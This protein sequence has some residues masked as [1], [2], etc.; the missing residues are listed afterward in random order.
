M[1]TVKIQTQALLKKVRENRVKH[2][3]E[4]EEAMAGYREEV[5]RELNENLSKATTGEDVPH[6][7]SLTQPTSYCHDYDRVIAMLEMS[8]ETAVELDSREFDRYVM[9]NWEWKD[10]VVGTNAL[11]LKGKVA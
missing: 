7:L 10:S 1:K 4:F 9:D 2:L 11:Y 3:T 6:F 8:T 5:V